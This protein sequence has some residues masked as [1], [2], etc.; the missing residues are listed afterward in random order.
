MIN[1]YQST[2]CKYDNIFSRCCF[3][4]SR[5]ELLSFGTIKEK[6]EL[7]EIRLTLLPRYEQYPEV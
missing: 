6:G 3:Y 1:S 4:C 2:F 7:R 5:A